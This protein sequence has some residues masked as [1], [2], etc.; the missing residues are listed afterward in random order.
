MNI[1]QFARHIGKSHPAVLKAIKSGR[2]V[3]SVRRDAQGR[4]VDIDPV[5]GA[6]EWKNRAK[7]PPPARDPARGPSAAEAADV[8]RRLS[9]VVEAD[10]DETK[11]LALNLV[12]RVIEGAREVL[13]AAKER[14]PTAAELVD[15]FA[16]DAGEDAAPFVSGCLSGA[17]E[18]GTDLAVE[19]AREAGRDAARGYPWFGTKEAS[20]G[21]EG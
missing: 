2:L 17:C 1:S 14:E 18:E 16:L 12:P 7:L 11:R 21:N 8:A 9:A 20:D 5:E 10:F 19:I 15:V 6:R 4:V 13:R 3:R